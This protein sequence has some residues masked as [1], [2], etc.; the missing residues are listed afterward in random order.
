LGGIILFLSTFN[1][2]GC[3]QN[4]NERQLIVSENSSYNFGETQQLQKLCHNFLITNK[5]KYPSK[6]IGIKSSCS[7]TWAKD[8]ENWLG[9]VIESGQTMELP[10][11]LSTGI[12]Q[13]IASGMVLL[14]YQNF[15]KPNKSPFDGSIVL[16]VIASVKPDYLTEPLL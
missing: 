4:H 14:K 10:I 2:T 8:S 15:D 11:C 12:S 16:E 7:C 5:S 13:D 6:I 3:L 9:K 1:I